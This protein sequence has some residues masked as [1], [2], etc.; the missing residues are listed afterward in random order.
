MNEQFDAGSLVPVIDG[1]YTLSTARD[2]FRRFGAGQHLG[3]IVITV[4]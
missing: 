3:K 1:S 2:A 4:Q